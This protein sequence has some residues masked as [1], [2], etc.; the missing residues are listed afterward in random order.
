MHGHRSDERAS[1][2][3]G[4]ASPPQQDLLINSGYFE[5]GGYRRATFKRLTADECPGVAELRWRENRR[6]LGEPSSS[7]APSP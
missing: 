7:S 5:E 1:V 4:F 6:G 2:L 3:G